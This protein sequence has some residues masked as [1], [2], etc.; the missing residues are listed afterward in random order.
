MI[1]TQF[2]HDMD[3]THG[4]GHANADMQLPLMSKAF[5]CP[6]LQTG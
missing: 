1:D 3:S 5:S 4:H 6:L 2:V